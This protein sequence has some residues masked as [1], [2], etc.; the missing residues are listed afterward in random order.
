MNITDEE[1]QEACRRLNAEE[2]KGWPFT[3]WVWE[4]SLE[5]HPSVRVLVTAMREQPWVPEPPVDEATLCW[6]EECAGRVPYMAEQYLRGDQDKDRGGLFDAIAFALN[7][8]K[9]REKQDG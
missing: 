6:R 8:A 9:E 7:W 1:G 3:R 5:A 4:R 2:A